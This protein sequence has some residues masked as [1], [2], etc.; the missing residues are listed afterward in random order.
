MGNFYTNITLRG[1]GQDEVTE[2][3]KR[4]GASAYVSPADRGFTVV[5]EE[6]C[7]TQDADVLKELAADLSA[8]FRCPALAAL[9]HDDDI[10]WLALYRD[11]EALDEY[12]SAPGYFEGE[13]LPPSGGDARRLCEVLG[14]AGAAAEKVERI[15]RAPDDEYT[16][17]CERH[18]D[19]VRALG[20]TPYA[21]GLGF[22]YVQEG[23][24]PSDEIDLGEMKFT[25]E[26]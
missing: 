10:L 5:Y 6:R 23:E 12:D 8:E 13:D 11:G 2:F 9:N 1:P 16:F 22:N 14:A 20:L 19:L 25:G 17:A 15:L 18:L 21:V 7:D 24:A 4:R 26:E 3:L